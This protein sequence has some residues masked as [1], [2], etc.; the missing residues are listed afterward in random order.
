MRKL[1]A[2]HFAVEFDQIEIT[3][4]LLN[5]LTRPLE[6]AI[7]VVHRET[8]GCIRLKASFRVH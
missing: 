6:F 1:S 2:L 5:E 8:I 7:V 4:L 3:E